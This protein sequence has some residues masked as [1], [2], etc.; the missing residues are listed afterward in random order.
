MYKRIVIFFSLFMLSIG[1]LI[2]K[3]YSI[4]DGN[5]LCDAAA[6]QSTY[7]LDIAKLRGLY[8]IVNLN[9]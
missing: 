5:W 4:S 6:N 2:L 9:Q 7:R 1:L 3:I 8:M